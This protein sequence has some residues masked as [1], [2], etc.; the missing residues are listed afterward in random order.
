MAAENNDY[1]EGK[2][3]S[4]ISDYFW[5]GL[6]V[7]LGLFLIFVVILLLDIW[8]TSTLHKQFLGR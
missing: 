5:I 2:K 7:G 8:P 6:F 4:R 3:T 1:R